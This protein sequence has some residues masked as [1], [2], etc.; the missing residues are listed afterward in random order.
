MPPAPGTFVTVG[1]PSRVR[2]PSARAP[3]ARAVLSH[4]PP[5]SA[6]AMICT[7]L[8]GSAALSPPAAS[9][10]PD[11]STVPPH[12]VSAR[13]ATS[14][15]ARPVRSGRLRTGEGT[16]VAREAMGGPFVTEVSRSE[17]AGGYVPAASWAQSSGR[18][19]GCTARGRHDGMTVIGFHASHEQVHPRSC[20]RRCSRPRRPASRGDVL[21][22]LLAVERAA[23]TVGLRLVLARRRAQA[24]TACRSAW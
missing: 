21:G 23:G 13:P 8:T 1:R 5:G 7:R 19:W 11:L 4:P 14:T 22:P 3:M 15:E 24:T 17:S 2:N 9:S 6:G 12:P 20:S 10:V 18:V 16:R